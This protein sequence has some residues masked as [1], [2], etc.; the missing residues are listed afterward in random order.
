MDKTNETT[1]QQTVTPEQPQKSYGR[2]WKKW[3]PVY[4]IIAAAIYSG[5][6]YFVLSKQ[7][8][9]PNTQ[10][11]IRADVSPAPSIASD[12]TANWKTYTNTKSGLSF[13][14]PSDWILTTAD[15]DLNSSKRTNLTLSFKESGKEYELIIHSIGYG[16]PPSDE[17]K[18]EKISLD[19]EAF[20]KTIFITNKKPFF[21]WVSPS[22]PNSKVQKSMFETI[23]IDLPQSN[24]DVYTKLFNQILSTFKFTDQKQ[25]EDTSNWKTYTSVTEKASFKYP[26]DWTVTKAAIPSNIPNADQISLQAPSGTVKIHWVSALDGFGGGCDDQAPLGEDSCPLVTVIDKTPIKSA[27]GLFVVSG[28][29]TKDGKVFQPWMA[30]Q[31]NEGITATQRSLGYTLFQGRNNKSATKVNNTTTAF[32]TSGAYAEGPDLSQTDANAYFAKPEVKQAKL[33]FQ[34]LSY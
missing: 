7:N 21:I 28:T 2:N 5:V 20:N 18:S 9:R 30:V 31:G 14:Y 13:Q 33:I 34:S 23:Q 12:L 15:I 6:Y 27:P 8:S 3:I 10:P 24:T 19:D 29:F 32:S 4:L 25:A 22:D 26:P 16:G 1:D 17:T 11:A